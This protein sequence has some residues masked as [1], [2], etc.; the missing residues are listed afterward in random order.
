M[1]Q[2]VFRAFG[3]DR[4]YAGVEIDFRPF[5]PGDF[6]APLPEQSKNG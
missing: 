4:P 1:R 5:H 3:P 2:A 6:A